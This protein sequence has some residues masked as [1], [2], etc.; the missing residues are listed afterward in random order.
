MQLRVTALLLTLLICA[1]RTASADDKASADRKILRDAIVDALRRDEPGGAAVQVPASASQAVRQWISANREALDHIRRNGGLREQP[2][3]PTASDQR[4][5]AGVPSRIYLYVFDWHVSGQLIVYG[6]TGGVGKAYMLSD[7]AKTALPLE[8]R[9]SSTI[10]TVAKEA[11]DPLA[12]VVV[13]EFNDKLESTQL[14]VRPDDKNVGRI[15]MHARDAIVHGHLLRYEPQPN[16]DTLGYWTDENDWASW[17]FEITDP[18]TYAVEILQGCG[19]GN[20]GSTVHIAVDNQVLNATVE[21]TGGFQNFVERN[22]GRLKFAKPGRYT[23]EVKPMKKA[24]KAVMDL[25]SVTLM[26]AAAQ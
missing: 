16:K 17:E 19:K 9:G 22:V 13:L 4:T 2:W 11:P 3:G 26:K 14:V 7:S 8:R 23:L 15:F 10:L 21:D 5:G 20:G 24:A 1:T 18:G 6:L 12:T 25:R